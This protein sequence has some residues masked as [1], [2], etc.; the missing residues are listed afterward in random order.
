MHLQRSEKWKLAV[1]RKSFHFGEQISTLS[2]SRG[3]VAVFRGSVGLH[4]LVR[5]CGILHVHV[6]GTVDVF[7]LSFMKKS[8]ENRVVKLARPG[9]ELFL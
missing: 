6:E 3:E 7:K 8:S 1:R 9:L 2:F 4:H 5:E